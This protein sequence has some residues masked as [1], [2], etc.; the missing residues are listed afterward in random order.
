[1]LASTEAHFVPQ[2]VDLFLTCQYAKAMAEGH[3]FRYNPGDAPSTGAT[4]LLHTAV[5]AA[6]HAAGIRGEGLVAFAVLTGAA[7]YVAAVVVAYRAAEDWAGSDVAVLAAVLVMLGGPVVWGFLYGAD[8]ALFLFLALFLLWRWTRAW[9]LGGAASSWAWAGVL[10]ALARP[11]G[12]LIGVV[13]A[14]SPTS[15]WPRTTARRPRWAS[16]RS[17]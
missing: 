3:P 14:R 11:E 6:A 17:T 8:I 13:L 16:W 15:R 9:V 1:M 12:L 7:L 2:V 10:L 5:L 4:S